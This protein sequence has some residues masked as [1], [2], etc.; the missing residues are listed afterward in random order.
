MNKV[1]FVC[2]GNICR[3]AAAEGIMH[4]LVE[5][6][7]RQADFLLD[8]AGTGAWHV[9]EGAD[10]R[11]IK[12][13]K[14]RGYELESVSRQIKPDDFDEFDKILVM[15]E[16]NRQGLLALNPTGKQV[17]K[18]DFMTRYCETFDLKDVPDP[19]YQGEQGFELVLDILEEACAN[20][21]KDL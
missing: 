4:K 11:M 19:Y 20:L 9:G 3:S 15:D 8:S 21:F 18:I 6:N 17:E 2:L 5:Q 14:E 16:S 10:S 13:A 12:H 1:L 7:G